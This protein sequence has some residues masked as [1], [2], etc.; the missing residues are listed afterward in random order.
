MQDLAGLPSRLPGKA[1][2]ASHQARGVP[3]LLTVLTKRGSGSPPRSCPPS[4]RQG[5]KGLQG[6]CP[7]Q[8][9]LPPLL[10]VAASEAA[11]EAPFTNMATTRLLRK[12]PALLG[13]MPEDSGL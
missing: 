7:S 3:A 6:N 13:H 10:N 8:R 2:S 1:A 5:P 4:F 12:A 11:L 9:W